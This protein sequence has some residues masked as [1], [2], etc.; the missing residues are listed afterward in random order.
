M[1]TSRL[2]S[3][4]GRSY[5]DITVVTSGSAVG[6]STATFAVTPQQNDV[7][8][9][10][11]G[12]NDTD[13]TIPSGYIEYTGGIITGTTTIY[14]YSC[15][16]K[17]MGATPD[18]SINLNDGNDTSAFTYYI[19]R[20]VQTES[21][22]VETANTI[23]T[24]ST[25]LN[26]P[27]VPVFPKC[28]VL[29]AGFTGNGAS[30]VISG[31]PSGYSGFL[32]VDASGNSD[33]YIGTAYKTITTTGTED[34]GAFSLTNTA[35]AYAS[36]SIVVRPF[37]NSFTLIEPEFV[38]V[39]QGT[40]AATT[41]LT[42]NKPTGTAEG[43]LMIAFC[44]ST[45]S[46]NS[47]W[48]GDTDWTEVA[49][50]GTPPAVRVAYKV[51]GASEGASYTFTSSVSGTL[52]GIII[53]YRYAAYDAVGTIAQDTLLLL[54]GSV[55]VTTQQSKLL[56]FA[57]RNANATITAQTNMT[58]RGSRTTAPSYRLA[59]QDIPEGPSG[60]REMDAASAANNPSA[61]MISI[62]PTRTP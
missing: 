57:A 10:T 2:K 45:V 30:A 24:S 31:G 60:P 34:P 59:D 32:G 55:S 16:Y 52:A 40:G 35:V 29:V 54:P 22:V 47:T 20:G 9:M 44:C 27:S 38:A 25:N 19:L 39:A 49:D 48:T 41:S 8:F 50:E 43:D 5:S 15:F 17:V 46:S 18:T 3:C 28:M 33:T 62:K 61:V 56:A 23:G 4:T 53:T 13:W 42:I 36:T 51:A 26:P 1:L 6:S 37:S 11:V 7:V 12:F 58:S 14:R 21:P